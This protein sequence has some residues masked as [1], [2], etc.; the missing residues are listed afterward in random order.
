[1]FPLFGLRTTMRENLAIGAIFKAV[2]LMRSYMLRGAF[3]T[4]RLRPRV[5]RKEN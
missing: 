2:S 1:M 3:E 4:I 5:C